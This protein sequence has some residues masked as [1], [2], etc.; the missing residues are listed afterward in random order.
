MAFLPEL[1]THE[2][3]TWQ[4]S[5]RQVTD[6]KWS[7][8]VYRSMLKY[9]GVSTLAEYLQRV[10]ELLTTPAI[11]PEPVTP[12]PL[13][14][15]ATLDYFNAVWQLHFDRK[16]PLIRLFGAERIAR[17]VYD[18]NT[19]KEVQLTGELP[20]RHPEEYASLGRSNEI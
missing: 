7:I 18:V 10:N 8:D 13:E 4:G 11:E 3:S 15:V 19:G 9:R 2:P 14:L 1:L 20:H 12:S 5:P 16:K 17:L 6:G